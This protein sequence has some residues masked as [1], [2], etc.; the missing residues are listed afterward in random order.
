MTLLDPLKSAFY[1][2]TGRSLDESVTAMRKTLTSLFHLLRAKGIELCVLRNYE[3][4]PN[5]VGRDMDCIPS[6]DN[7]KALM[8]VFEMLAHDNGDGLIVIRRGSVWL[9][10]FVNQ[11]GSVLEIDAI[12]EIQGWWGAAYLSNEE[13]WASA[14]REGDWW[15]PRPAHEAAIGFFQ[16]LLWGGCYKK[17]YVERLPAL[18]APEEEAEEFSRI[19]RERFGPQWL[20]LL[21][22]IKDKNVECIEASAAGLRKSLWAKAVRRDPLRT[23]SRFALIV[24][25]EGVITVRRWGLFV[26][27]TG[28]DG[29]GKTSIAKLLLE[30]RYGGSF[31]KARYFHFRPPIGRGLDGLRPIP[32][33][34]QA[35]DLT[36]QP[37]LFDKVLSVPRILFNLLRFQLG[38]W[39][40]VF[41]ALLRQRV[42]IADRYFYN[43]LFF[44]ESVRYFGPSWL[45]RFCARLFPR[46]DLILAL[47]ADPEVIHSRK[48]ELPVWAV[49][50]QL[51]R[52]PMICSLGEARVID[53]DRPMED[54]IQTCKK[55]LMEIATRRNGAA[56]KQR[57]G[58]EE[59]LNWIGPILGAD[60]EH[61]KLSASILTPP[62]KSED[63]SWI[64]VAKIGIVPTGCSRLLIPITSPR[65]AGNSLNVYNA[66]KPI[67]RLG[68]VLLSA[69]LRAGIAQRL[70]RDRA[71]LCVRAGIPPNLWK[72]HI[73]QEYLRELFAVK[74]VAISVSLGTGDRY[75]KPTVQIMNQGGEI[76]GFAKIGWD[77]ETIE[78]VRN[79]EA[80]LRNL[81]NRSFSTARVPRVIHSGPWRSLYMFVSEAPGGRTARSDWK[82]TRQHLEFL[83][84]LQQP[85]HHRSPLAGSKF[86]E[87][88][89]WQ[90]E[91]LKSAGFSEDF[92][93]LEGAL[94]SSY[95]RLGKSE[96][97]FGMKHGD[98]VPSNILRAQE[99]LYVFD[100][101]YAEEAS[102]LGC[103]LF[104][105]LVWT[106]VLLRGQSARQIYKD[107]TRPGPTHQAI[108]TYFQEL[109]VPGEFIMPLLV[110]HLADILSWYLCR[111]G[112]SVAR[113]GQE[114]RS[115]WRSLLTLASAS[116]TPTAWSDA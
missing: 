54:V 38:Y 37:T 58:C 111:D 68:K 10:N 72:D 9:V 47:R 89:E 81:E 69:G 108:K 84:E 36:L 14:T 62:T 98:F 30:E 8:G 83:W 107:F 4:L 33:R 35:H 31:R 48:A 44:P 75:R 59:M 39:L 88:L 46:P 90:I 28:P 12:P 6:D 60:E 78:L 96:V 97:P 42:V 21:E 24:W 116:E 52:L 26:V 19:I 56:L 66:Q 16:H 29:V 34:T 100:W 99:K 5:S 7:F 80:T 112:E 50:E 74:S 102:P 101:E 63:K 23:L 57:S 91:G 11:N 70:L 105:F 1:R 55:A 61:V 45:A 43:Y 27:L 13:I 77:A 85:K 32:A 71:S 103:D 104:H 41:P 22:W 114:V 53:A 15:V 87:R 115:V 25:R 110:L 2:E 64:E 79:E 51:A 94:E 3:E 86:I 106:A 73:L 95:R 20:R 49:R 17:K 109:G 82:I 67:A 65:A 113:K 18:I 76:L 93:L 92:H 40:H